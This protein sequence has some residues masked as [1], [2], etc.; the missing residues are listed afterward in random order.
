MSDGSLSPRSMKNSVKFDLNDTIDQ[1]IALANGDYILTIEG[2]KIKL[3]VDS[4]C[5]HGDKKEAL[6][7][8]NL[9]RKSLLKNNFQ[10][11]S[12]PNLG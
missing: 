7:Q 9:I 1:A 5:I 10:L 12:L 11:V 8:S 3:K 6:D 4:I 2:E